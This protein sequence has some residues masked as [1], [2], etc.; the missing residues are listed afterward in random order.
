MDDDNAQIEL[1]EQHLNKTSQISQRMTNI[2]SKFDTR[3]IRLEKSISP[4]H[5]STQS[6]TRISD[7]IDKTIQAIDRI[8]A[9]QEG[10]AAEEALILRGPNSQHLKSYFDAIERLNAQIAFG[11]AERSAK[12]TGRVIETGGKKLCQ[13]H[14]KLVAEASSGP[15]LDPETYQSAPQMQPIPPHILGTLEPLVVF[16]R[17]L[18][19][20]STH[21]THPASYG[22]SAA[23]KDCQAGYAE[24]RAGW[25]KKCIEPTSKRVLERVEKRDTGSDV[26]AGRLLG[27]WV[28]GVLTLAEAEHNL[29][30]RLLPFSNPQA[31]QSTYAA[32]ISPVCT[33]VSTVL[34]AAHAP[35]RRSLSAHV[36][37]A[38]TQYSSVSA[39]QPRWD[40]VMR[41]RAARKENELAESLHSL[42]AICLRSFPEFLA[43]VRAA[44]S[45][46]PMT[47]SVGVADFTLSTV[48][49]LEMLPQVQDAV[50]TALKTLGDGNWRMG[51]ASLGTLQ[52]TTDEDAILEHY[53]HDV[54]TILIKALE[55]RARALKR[56]QTGSIFMLNNLS[57]IRSNILLN[58][59][60]AIDDLLPAQSQDSLNTA[61][62]QAKNSYFE[63]NWSPLLSN[64]GE[65]K[66]GRQV[67]K[68]Q[69]T[70]FFDGLAEVATTHQAF[71]LNKQ[72]AELRE[73]LAEEV[74]NLVMP[75]FQRFSARH[76]AADFTKNPSKYIRAT[77]EEV[78][79]QIRALFR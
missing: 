36:F 33:L 61:F 35:V 69:W 71:P 31:L 10:V 29:M 26:E 44:G 55:G 43:D 34:S 76:Q 78:A 5:S 60:S 47:L 37:L 74:N 52:P 12:D 49:Y 72:D 58:P 16:M 30:E 41:Q 28:A 64:L 70:G 8:A 1:L 4:L 9:R 39:L 50:S 3:L 46:I 32:F 23:L 24:M 63:A 67:V 14:T 18:P 11:S 27:R 7:N 15:T 25:A 77:P 75:A 48:K 40:V 17:T 2:L 62:R 19:V 56:A 79:Q 13:L 65:G 20:P 73:K 45:A 38:F 22:L 54:M 6:L 68:D 42:R 51:D 66:G 59:R 21:P 57:Y 53:L